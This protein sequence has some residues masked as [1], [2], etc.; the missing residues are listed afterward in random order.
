M[1]V[2]Y[3]GLFEKNSMNSDFR[4]I[5]LLQLVMDGSASAFEEIY[6]LTRG[7]VYSK[8]FQILR[9]SSDSEDILQEVYA[10]I[11]LRSLQFDPCKGG[12][13]SWINGI[14]RH[15]ALDLLRLRKRQPLVSTEMPCEFDNTLDEI[16]CPDC[17]PLD[18]VIRRQ[19]A[20]AVRGSLEH[21]PAG[22]RECL[23]L[24]FFEDLS[25]TEIASKIGIP[26]GTVK[27]WVSRS[28]GSLRPFL[29]EHR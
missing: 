20:N 14:A 11:W 13:V 7:N 15:L 29:K 16:V 4:L 22:A 21:L 9:N 25:H 6:R 18:N 26:L 28:Y 23:T 10:R 8:I 27:T 17:Q 19:R 1:L 2:F 3:L 24:A 12:V 5:A